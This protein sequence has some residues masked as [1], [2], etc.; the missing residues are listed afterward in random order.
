MYG[1]IVCFCPLQCFQVALRDEEGR[2]SNS[3]VQP[4]SLY[5]LGCVLL[6]NPEASVCVGVCVFQCRF[7]NP[8][9]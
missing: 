7:Y 6:E 9:A 8:D 3:Y 4:Y 2:V 5:E 1:V